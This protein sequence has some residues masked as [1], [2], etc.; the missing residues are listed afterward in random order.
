[1][2]KK[3]KKLFLNYIKTQLGQIHPVKNIPGEYKLF[4]EYF[5]KNYSHL[6]PSEKKA[7]I[8]DFGCGM[9]HFLYFLQ[10]SGY[11][12]YKGIDISPE[13]VE[14]CLKN[15]LG[16][17][18]NIQYAGGEEYL[19]RVKEKYDVVVMN[20]VIEHIEKKRII[21]V[22]SLIRERLK[23]R[24]RLIVKT[25]NLANPVTGGS[26]RYFDFTHT[27]GFTE[28]SLQQVFRLAGF[29]KIKIYPQNIWVFNPLVNFVGRGL[30]GTFNLFFRFLFLLYGRK[31]TKIFTK[32]M[33]AVVEK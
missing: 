29:E 32:H 3:T 2:N 24:G 19:K 22:L 7:L 18:R 16:N 4:V 30:Q 31:T 27:I 17:K 12:N 25:P 33:I 26:S 14:F 11:K 15:K 23:E 8:L 13:A 5:C 6:L 10:K 9:G 20:D 28:E 1:M 21:S